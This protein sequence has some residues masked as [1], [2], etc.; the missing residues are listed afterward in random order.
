MKRKNLTYRKLSHGKY[1]VRHGK[2]VYLYNN[3]RAAKQLYKALLKKEVR[4][5]LHANGKEDRS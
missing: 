1:Q 3:S 2:D 4:K 5:E